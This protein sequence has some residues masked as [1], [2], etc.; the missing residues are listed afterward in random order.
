ML[1]N[2]AQRRHQIVQQTLPIALAQRHQPQGCRDPCGDDRVQI[3]LQGARLG[4]AETLREQTEGDGVMAGRR[5]LL[6]RLQKPLGNWRRAQGQT[7][8]QKR[9]S[10]MLTFQA[11]FFRHFERV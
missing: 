5:A 7:G 11:Q 1:Q 3:A 2:I 6:D 9:L 4:D 10:R 8:S